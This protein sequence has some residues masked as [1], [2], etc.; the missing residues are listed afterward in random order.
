MRK[1]V[2]NE[3]V[4]FSKY[5][6]YEVFT[7]DFFIFREICLS[8]SCMIYIQTSV[9]LLPLPLTQVYTLQLG[10]SYIMDT[11]PVNMGSLVFVWTRWVESTLY[12]VFLLLTASRKFVNKSNATCKWL[13]SWLL[14]V[15]SNR[16]FYSCSCSYNQLFQFIKWILVF[17]WCVLVMS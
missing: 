7:I 13:V 12:L 2:Y 3:K 16:C 5:K 10:R 8:Q 1:V 11:L 14:N 17:N 15:S 9:T 4:L 6:H